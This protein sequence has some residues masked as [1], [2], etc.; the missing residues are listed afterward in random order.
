MAKVKHHVNKDT[1][2][3]VRKVKVGNKT[4]YET[5]SQ[6]KLE[7]Y[8]TGRSLFGCIGYIIAFIIVVKIFFL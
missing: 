6:E 7:N 2:D 3:I 1:G 8:E 4:T 5:I